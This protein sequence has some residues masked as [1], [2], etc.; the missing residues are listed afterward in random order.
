MNEDATAELKELFVAAKLFT[1]P[2]PTKLLKHL[3]TI[4]TEKNDIV[5][6]FFSGSSTT[7]DAVMQMN[8]EDN[9]RR[10]FIMIQLPEICANDSLAKEAGYKTICELALERIRRAA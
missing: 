1:H 2:K 4:A 8:V 9:G 7:A 6:D 5:L 3:I 10:K